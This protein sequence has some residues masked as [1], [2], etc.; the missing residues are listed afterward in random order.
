[1]LLYNGLKRQSLTRPHLIHQVLAEYLLLG[2]QE[3]ISS[4][5]RYEY[6]GLY[7]L[8]V[9]LNLNVRCSDLM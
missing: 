3:T 2:T 1:M 4:N 9:F 7:N 6:N 5:G 8:Y